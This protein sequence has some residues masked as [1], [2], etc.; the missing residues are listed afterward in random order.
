MKVLA[1]S[2]GI[3]SM[4]MLHLFRDE[5]DIIVAHFDHGIRPSSKADADFVQKTAKDYDLECIVKR[6][7]LGTDCSEALARE[8][9]YAFLKELAQKHG[10][11]IYTAHHQDDL[12]ETIAINLHR[13]TGWRGLAPFQDADIE[14]PLLEWPKSKIYRYATENQVVFRQDQSNTD[15]KYLRNRLRFQLRDLTPVQ[16]AELWDL[17]QKQCQLNSEI[18]QLG[19]EII[20]T[21]SDDNEFERQIFRE[22]DDAT[23]LELLRQ[24]LEQ[25]QHFLTYPQLELALDAIRTYHKGKKF[26]LPQ[27]KF[28]EFSRNHCK[29]LS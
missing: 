17:Y 23:A 11:K 21:I 9:R 1:V 26:N 18:L 15:D 13:G 14:R 2:G 22:L 29:I 20:K 10:A 3:D 25:H 4:V 5:K 8:R 27:D 28:L 12:I 16:K 19:S 24:L 7:E 6:E